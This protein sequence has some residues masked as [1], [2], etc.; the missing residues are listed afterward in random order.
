M[1][2]KQ[3]RYIKTFELHDPNE[4]ETKEYFKLI[5]NLL[6]NTIYKKT[7]NFYITILNSFSYKFLKN[8]TNFPNFDVGIQVNGNKLNLIINPITFFKKSQTEMLFRL[9]HEAEH[10][11]RRHIFIDIDKKKTITFNKIVSGKPIE[12]EIPIQLVGMDLEVNS[13]RY[14]PKN[15][16]ISGGK[17]YYRAGSYLL[18]E[19]IFPFLNQFQSLEPYKDFETYCDEI[20]ELAK[21]NENGFSIKD[22]K[23]CVDGYLDFPDINDWEILENPDKE[24]FDENELNS[25]LDYIMEMAAKTAG[26]NTPKHY[27]YLNG[28]NKIETYNWKSV[29]DT[30]CASCITSLKKISKRKLNKR[31]I[32]KNAIIQG[33]VNNVEV[34][35]I[36]AFDTSGSI[37]KKDF[38]ISLNHLNKLK[39]TLNSNIHVL[40]FDGNVHL[41]LELNDFNFEKLMKSEITKSFTKGGTKFKPIFEEIKQKKIKADVLLIFTDGFSSEKVFKNPLPSVPTLWVLTPENKKPSFGKFIIMKNKCQD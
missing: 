26:N 3:R 10:L 19:G 21:K 30:Y 12:V 1:I 31:G 27:E 41:S 11:L 33:Y 15:Y 4:K 2:V 8:G 18:E 6:T 38:V 37:S 16:S 32:S 34:K 35:I 9:I 7:E 29:L 5:L 25:L 22:G 28:I 20:N 23:I 14:D 36:A 17:S 13:L 40:F 24:S 39:K